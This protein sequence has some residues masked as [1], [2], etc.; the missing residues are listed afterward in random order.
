MDFPH[1]SYGGLYRTKNNIECFQQVCFLRFVSG[2]RGR[3]KCAFRR[4]NMCSVNL[5]QALMK[6]ADLLRI[7]KLCVYDC[8]NVGNWLPKFLHDGGRKTLCFRT[9][10]GKSLPQDIRF[11]S[12]F[13]YFK[14]FHN[15][16]G[17]LAENCVSRIIELVHARQ[18]KRTIPFFVLIDISAILVP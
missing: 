9:K 4:L 15:T 16:S 1:P 7:V 11:V 13:V 17:I 18:L 8:Y 3:T 2:N 14:I 6:C 5:A 10:V 12:S